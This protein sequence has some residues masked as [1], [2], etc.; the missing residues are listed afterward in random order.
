[1]YFKHVFQ[2]FVFQLLHNP[3]S[4]YGSRVILATYAA[5]LLVCIASW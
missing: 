1:M 3:A 2:I 4:K 5:I